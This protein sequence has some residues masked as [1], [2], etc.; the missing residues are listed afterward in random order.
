M[1]ARAA[2]ARRAN[3]LAQPDARERIVER[4]GRAGPRATPA[5]PRPSTVRRRAGAAALGAL[6]G[7]K[8]KAPTRDA[9]AARELRPVDLPGERVHR[10]RHPC[11]RAAGHGSRTAC[12]PSTTRAAGTA[13]RRV[14]AAR[15]TARA[16]GRGRLGIGGRAGTRGARARGAAAGTRRRAGHGAPHRGWCRSP[17]VRRVRTSAGGV[18]TRASVVVVTLR[19]LPG[20]RLNARAAS[21]CCPRQPTAAGASATGERCRGPSATSVRP[22]ATPDGSHWSAG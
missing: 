12:A 10:A 4:P 22:T 9:G 7:A 5:P 6:T 21:P 2:R 11:P 20:R 1:S 14:T 16:G 8:R 15:R 18:V 13:R 3:S 17:T 19:A